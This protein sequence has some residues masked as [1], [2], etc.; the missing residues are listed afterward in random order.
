[1]SDPHPELVPLAAYLAAREQVAKLEAEPA[2]V[3]IAVGLTGY[4]HREDV[5]TPSQAIYA[6]WSDFGRLQAELAAVRER[7]A[8]LAAAVG[9]ARQEIEACQRDVVGTYAEGYFAGVLAKL[10][11]PAPILARVRRQAKLEALEGLPPAEPT[12]RRDFLTPE[13]K[14]TTEGY[15][16]YRK[17]VDAAIAQLR[18]ED[19]AD[20]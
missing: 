8:A 11:D 16:A 3:R 5:D 14:A 13:V 18:Q 12:L 2:E 17:A 1:M 9:V 10:A 7:E 15:N 6:L 20:G 4:D 19:E